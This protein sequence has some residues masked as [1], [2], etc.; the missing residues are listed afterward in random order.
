MMNTVNSAASLFPAEPGTYVLFFELTQPLRASVGRLGM[1]DF[2]AGSL[3]YVGSALGPGGLRS[4][5]TRHFGRP[6]RPHWHIDYLTAL[7]PAM[8]W[9]FVTSRH[10]LECRWVR[11]LE[12]RGAACAVV[13]FGSSDCPPPRCKAHL[14]RLPTGWTPD[15]VKEA[16]VWMI[17]S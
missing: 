4:R 15:H 11:E 5:L 9:F 1:C 16:L 6:Q 2:P 10:R 17:P 12:A 13:G 7:R 14:L 8:G 3:V